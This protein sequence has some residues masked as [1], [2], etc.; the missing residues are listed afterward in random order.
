MCLHIAILRIDCDKIRR[1]FELVFAFFPV[2]SSHSFV[3]FVFA[4]VSIFL[5]VWNIMIVKPTEQ[6]YFC[7][8]IECEGA[9]GERMNAA[10][11]PECI[12]YFALS[13]FHLFV[14]LISLCVWVCVL[15]LFYYILDMLLWCWLRDS[16]IKPNQKMSY[17]Y[18]CWL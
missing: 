13:N 10:Y 2:F 5:D 12:S 16:Q 4:S 1:N 8:Q 3:L 9:R 18:I 14:C 15:V 7:P 17:M 11:V 6:N